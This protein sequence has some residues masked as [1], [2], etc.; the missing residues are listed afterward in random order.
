[1]HKR[2]ITYVFICDQYVIH[3]PLPPLIGSKQVQRRAAT[4]PASFIY[5][6]RCNHQSSKPTNV[7][8]I[9]SYYQLININILQLLTSSDVI[10]VFHDSS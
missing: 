5:V 2:E 10:S 3:S 6:F 4:K 8:H 9:F 1:M 7:E